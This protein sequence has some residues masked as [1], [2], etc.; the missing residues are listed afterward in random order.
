M[1]RDILT[2]SMIEEDVACQLTDDVPDAV[3]DIIVGQVE[4]AQEARLRIKNEGIVVR[5]IGGMIIPHPA[6]K[7]Q[8]DAEKIIASLV[9]KYKKNE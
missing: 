1:K 4:I 2:L 7:I 9:G 8:N 6:I 5:N 3:F